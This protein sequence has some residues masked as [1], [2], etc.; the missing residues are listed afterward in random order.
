MPRKDRKSRSI[1][2]DVDDA[3]SSLLA[4]RSSHRLGSSDDSPRTS[5]RPHHSVQLDKYWGDDGE[6][7]DSWLFHVRS[8]AGLEGWTP[9]LT[10]RHAAVALSGRARTEYRVFLSTADQEVTWE[11][12]EQFLHDHFGPENP[13]RY[14][15]HKLMSIQQRSQETVSA[16]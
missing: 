1:R 4:S 7:L 9:A 15:T 14:Y 13:V 16:Y 10:L 8:V 3:T 12:F 2:L 11:G 5:F 6:D